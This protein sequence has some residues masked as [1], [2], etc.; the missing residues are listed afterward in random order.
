MTQIPEHLYKKLQQVTLEVKKTLS[1]RGVAIPIKNRDGSISIG[2]YTVKKINSYYQIRDYSQEVVVDQINLP[3]SAIVLANGLALGKY[4]DTDLL[5]KDRYY[6][7][8]VFEEDHH[9]KIAVKNLDK[10]L[11]RAELAFTMS[12]VKKSKKDI[13]KSDILR[14][15]D[16]LKRFA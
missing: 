13:Y 3:H 8:A 1:Q 11:D 2:N 10:N 4:L 6:G 7:Y 9:K 5:N 12:A 14:T 16:K 15:F